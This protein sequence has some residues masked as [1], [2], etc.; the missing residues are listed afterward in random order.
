MVVMVYSLQYTVREIASF[1]WPLTPPGQLELVAFEWKDEII[2]MFCYRAGQGNGQIVME[3][4]ARITYIVV[5]LKTVDD[6]YLLIGFALGEKHLDLF[7]G[8]CFN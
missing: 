4:E 1:L 8:R 5:G 7:D 6:I 2:E 3:A